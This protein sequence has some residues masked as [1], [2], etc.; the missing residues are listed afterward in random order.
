MRLGSYVPTSQT[1]GWLRDGHLLDRLASSRE[2]D[3]T[4]RAGEFI[5]RTSCQSRIYPH[6]HATRTLSC[7]L[8]FEK[9]GC[10]ALTTGSSVKEL[11]GTVCQLPDISTPKDS[12]EDRSMSPVGVRRG[13]LYR[14]VDFEGYRTFT[15]GNSRSKKKRQLLFLS[16]HG[17]HP[18]VGRSWAFPLN[19]AIC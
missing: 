9:R 19:Q 10:P 13:A 17:C 3:L 11:S 1:P 5:L 4:N 2:Y 15:D 12:I 14:K 6:S 8:L 7:K 16:T 18:C